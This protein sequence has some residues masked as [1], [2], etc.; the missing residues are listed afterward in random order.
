MN[1]ITQEEI[2][3]IQQ[4]WSNEQSIS[5]LRKN[6]CAIEM[7]MYK[8]RAQRK[9][10]ETLIDVLREQS[11]ENYDT[12]EDLEM[13]ENEHKDAFDATFNNLNILSNTLLK[14]S[15]K[16]NS[17]PLNLEMAQVKQIVQDMIKKQNQDFAKMKQNYNERA[18]KIINQRKDRPRTLENEVKGLEIKCE[19]YKLLHEALC[20]VHN[21]LCNTIVSLTHKE[22]GEPL[23]NDS[24]QIATVVRNSQK[25][26]S[27]RVAMVGVHYCERLLKM[28][29]ENKK[30]NS[31]Q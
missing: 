7:V 16:E 8:E 4:K 18:L 2:Q 28:F 23:N 25:E 13:M 6:G 15:T 30:E 11:E 22:N 27:D 29:E 14:L 26:Y 21:D 17:V 24:A 12:I 19:K 1:Q 20:E 5:K 10:L 3:R 31:Q 9:H